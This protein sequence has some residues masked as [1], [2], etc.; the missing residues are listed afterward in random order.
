MVLPQT[1]TKDLSSTKTVIVT[2]HAR[3]GAGVKYDA[4]PAKFELA[5]SEAFSFYVNTQYNFIFT[6]VAGANG[7]AQIDFSVKSVADWNWGDPDTDVE[8]PTLSAANSYMVTPS[9]DAFLIP[10]YNA[11]KPEWG[12]LSRAMF[13]GADDASKLGNSWLTGANLKVG[14]LWTDVN[15]ATNTVIEAPRLIGSK[16]DNNLRILITPGADKGNALVI[17][18]DDQGTPDQ[19]NSTTDVIKYSWLIWNVDYSPI[20]EY[21][22]ST[23]TALNNAKGRWMD[24]NLGATINNVSGS[25]LSEDAN[26]YGFMYQ[27]GRPHPLNHPQY[28][29]NACENFYIRNNNTSS[30]TTPTPLDATGATVQIWMNNPMTHYVNGTDHSGLATLNDALWSPTSKTVYDPC[31]PGW[32]VPESTDWDTSAFTTIINYGT[33]G[34]DHGQFYPAVGYLSESNTYVDLHNE[35]YYASTTL[36]SVYTDFISIAYGAAS[37]SSHYRSLGY[38]IRCVAINN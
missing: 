28:G 24:R 1:I 5:A 16:D 13:D 2:Y 34:N 32:R 19:Y 6:F 17:L 9:G 33:L 12:Q 27:W 38:S 15:P 7:S 35:G 3:N 4:D 8:L 22:A 30:N 14:I 25:N 10:V 21:G 31:P 36:S 11:D 26:I 29:V 18:Y 37:V 23:T 20:P